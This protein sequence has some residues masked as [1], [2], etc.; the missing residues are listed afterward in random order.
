MTKLHLGCNNRKIHSYINIDIRPEVGPDIVDDCFVLSKFK[1]NSIDIIYSSH[2]IE[3]CK[4]QDY[5]KV[6]KRWYDLLKSSG[7]LRLSAPD[8]EA[9]CNY[10]LKTNDIKSIENLMYGDQKHDYGYHYIGLDFKTLSND[11]KEI[12]FT[13]I[14]R[15]DWRTTEHFYIDDYSQC[16][17]PRISYSTRRPEGNIE[18]TLVSLNIEATKL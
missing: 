1:E 7:I 4:R 2:M 8:F 3:H 11:L 14:H 9:L 5:K 17:L 6:L 10:Y 12:G 15:Y 13:D 18:G 16:Y